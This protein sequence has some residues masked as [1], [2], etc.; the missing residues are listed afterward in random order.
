MIPYWPQPVWTLGPWTIHGFGVAQAV[1][2]VGGYALA[3]RRARSAG[4]DELQMGRLFVLA[5][6]VGLTVGFLVHHVV[7]GAPWSQP[8]ES[9]A[10]LTAGALAIAVGAWARWGASGLLYV[11]ALASVAPLVGG[12][13][14][15][16]CF[17]AHDHRGRSSSGL[18]AVRFPEGPR[19]DLGLVEC[20]I[21]FAVAGPVWWLWRSRPP[22]G[23]VATIVGVASIGVRVVSSYLR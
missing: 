8:G 21:A 20:V 1:A 17:L 5:L 7:S 14:R 10:G 16:G 4:L 9:A 11:D 18:F 23:A 2:L 13:A 6:L 15:L 19:I 22:A 3:L 12:V